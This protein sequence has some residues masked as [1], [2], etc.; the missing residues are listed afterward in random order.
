MAI[1]EAAK[2]TVRQLSQIWS[3]CQTLWVCLALIKGYLSPNLHSLIWHIGTY[4]MQNLNTF[5]KNDNIGK[6]PMLYR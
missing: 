3:L 1:L 2:Y 5:E 6:K 4:R